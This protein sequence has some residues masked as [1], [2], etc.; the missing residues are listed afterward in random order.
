[1]IWNTLD[2][3]S[4]INDKFIYDY[5]KVGNCISYIYHA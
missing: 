5:Y 1:M 2:A 4:I 3:W